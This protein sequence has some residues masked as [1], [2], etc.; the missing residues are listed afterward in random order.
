MFYV[1]YPY[2]FRTGTETTET[3][4]NRGSRRLCGRL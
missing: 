1:R 3:G 2:L 4:G